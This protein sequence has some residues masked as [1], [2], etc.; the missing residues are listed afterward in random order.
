[1]LAPKGKHRSNRLFLVQNSWSEI[2]QVLWV[3]RMLAYTRQIPQVLPVPQQPEMTSHRLRV[4]PLTP[5]C[6]V[7]SGAVFCVIL[8]HEVFQTLKHSGSRN[9]SLGRLSP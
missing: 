5:I 4:H 3:I 2:A 7:S 9:S 6:T 1:M 8:T